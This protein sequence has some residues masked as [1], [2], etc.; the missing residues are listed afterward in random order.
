MTIAA[1]AISFRRCSESRSTEHVVDA[2]IVDALT[3]RSMG[4]FGVDAAD[5]AKTQQQSLRL[6]TVV[7]SPIPAARFWLLASLLALATAAAGLWELGIFN[8]KEFLEFIRDPEHKRL[9]YHAVFVTSIVVDR[10][11][12][13]LL[14]RVPPRARFFLDLTSLCNPT[15]AAVQIE[16]G[17]A[18]LLE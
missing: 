1:L 6:D 17:I 10:L 12:L 2:D 9:L 11:I 18:P 5:P 14:K 13:A 15:I 8:W 7:A 4:A 16:R 3:A